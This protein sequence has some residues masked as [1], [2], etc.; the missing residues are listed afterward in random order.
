MAEAALGEDCPR[1]PGLEYQSREGQNGR[2]GCESSFETP[3]VVTH[4][5]SLTASGHGCNIKL[6]AIKLM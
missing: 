6:K 1:E 3:P 4:Q 5:P 2:I